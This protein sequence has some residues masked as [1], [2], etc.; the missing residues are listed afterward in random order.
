MCHFCQ[1]PHIFYPLLAVIFI[2][3]RVL[4]D[5]W[6]PTWISTSPH[7]VTSHYT[8]LKSHIPSAL[9]LSPLHLKKAQLLLCHCYAKYLKY[10]IIHFLLPSTKSLGIFSYFQGTSALHRVTW[11]VSVKSQDLNLGSQASSMPKV[12]CYVA[13]EQFFSSINNNVYKKGIEVLHRFWLCSSF[14]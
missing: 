3:A 6:T 9:R 12:L 1:F 4:Y 5:A 8:L 11:R 13:S 14:D 7:H 10:P 2:T